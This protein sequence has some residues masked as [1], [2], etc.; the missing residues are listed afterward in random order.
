MPNYIDHFKSVLSSFWFLIFHQQYYR[1]YT[2]IYC[3]S[4]HITEYFCE[5][6]GIIAHKDDACIIRGPKFLPPSLR[7]NINQ[8]NALLGD[9]PTETPRKWNSQPLAVY[10]KSLILPTKTSPLVLSIMVILNHHSVDNGDV[11]V[12][13]FRVSF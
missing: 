12:Y 13:F 5:F 2:A 6:C 7:R 3:G 4:P 1:N 9:K 8:L 10:F 11:E